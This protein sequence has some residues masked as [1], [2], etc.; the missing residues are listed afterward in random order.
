MPGRTEKA[1]TSFFTCLFSARIWPRVAPGS[2]S[3]L[4]TSVRFFV[5]FSRSA[6]IRLLA[7]R[8]P[9]LNPAIAIVA[10]S[11]MS[12]TACPGDG[13]TLFMTIPS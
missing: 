3:E 13:K 10:P 1:A 5:P 6:M 4:H 8:C 9:T 2:P 11:A 7:K 12:A